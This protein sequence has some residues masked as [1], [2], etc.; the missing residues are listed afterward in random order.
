MTIESTL[1]DCPPDALVGARTMAH[2]AVQ[3]LSMAGRANIPAVAD[4]SHTVLAWDEARGGFLSNPM[5]SAEGEIAVGL[6]LSS[7]TL[8]VMRGD[9]THTKFALSGTAVGE[10]D[11]WLDS[12]LVEVGLKPTSSAA[13][14]F[15]LPQAV[16]EIATYL[17]HSGR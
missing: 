3:P 9:Q 7:L 1:R 4:Q 14:S 6:V 8:F 13:V 5:A 15:E 16:N 11:A 12:Q 10:A 17:S 2:K